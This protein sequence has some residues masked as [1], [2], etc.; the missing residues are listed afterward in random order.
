VRPK[1]GLV[2]KCDLNLVPVSGNADPNADFGGLV[3]LNRPRW[4]WPTGTEFAGSVQPVVLVAQFQS[5]LVDED[6]G[7]TAGLSVQ[8]NQ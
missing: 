1:P 6:D 7:L 5:G 2:L 8:E 3:G 4:H